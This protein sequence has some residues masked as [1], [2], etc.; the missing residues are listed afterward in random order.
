[1]K[2]DFGLVP[3]QINITRELCKLENVLHSI[4]QYVGS[5]NEQLHITDDTQV[6]LRYVT[7]YYPDIVHCIAIM[8]ILS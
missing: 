2:Q 3:I 4:N 7:P 6:Y 1:M 8:I 5:I